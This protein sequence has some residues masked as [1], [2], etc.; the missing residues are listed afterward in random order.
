MEKP[1]ALSSR[2]TDAAVTPLPTE[3]RTPPV[4]NM[5]LIAILPQPVIK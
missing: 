4:K 2:P 5:Y 1:R 3:E